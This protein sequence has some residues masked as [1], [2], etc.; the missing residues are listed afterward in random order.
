MIF[1]W[2]ASKFEE[3]GAFVGELDMAGGLQ[4]FEAVVDGVS[5]VAGFIDEHPFRGAAVL[6][7]V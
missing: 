5:A 3:P 4:D 2:V 6:E 7:D 1:A